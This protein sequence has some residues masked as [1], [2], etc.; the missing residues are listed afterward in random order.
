MIVET[1]VVIHPRNY[2]FLT[3]FHGTDL[4]HFAAFSLDLAMRKMS[5]GHYEQNSERRSVLETRLASAVTRTE[6]RTA[7]AWELLPKSEI[8]TAPQIAAKG[9]IL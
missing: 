7:C 9:G 5:R 2:Y 8:W 4:T 6:V 3:T 1:G